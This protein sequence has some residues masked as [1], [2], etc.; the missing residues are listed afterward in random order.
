M[1]ITYRKTYCRMIWIFL[2][3]Y[4]GWF[5]SYA[6]AS[7]SKNILSGKKV[8]VTVFAEDSRVKPLL[9]SAQIRLEEILA[10]NNAYVL[11]EDKTRELTD[12]FKTLEDPSAFVTAETFVENAKKFNIDQLLAM[13]ITADV[14]PGL[15]NYY[16]ATASADIRYIENES[17]H[18]NALTTPIMGTDYRCPASDGLT[19]NSAMGNAVQRAVE[20][21]CEIFGLDMMDRIRAKSVKL[22]LTPCS[23]L[24]K[25]HIEPRTPENDRS[26]WSLPDLENAGWRQ[27]KATCTARSH[28]GKLV[29]VCGY[30]I[31]TDWHRRPQRLYGS[32]VHVLDMSTGDTL[33]K[34]ECS[35]VEKNTREE[36]RTKQILDCTFISNWR[37][38]AAATG[39]HILLWDTQTGELLS[40]LQE[41]TQSGDTLVF[42]R[43]TDGN[44]YLVLANGKQQKN[45]Y[46][47][48]VGK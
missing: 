19:R 16:T 2:C 41:Q 24:P 45:I 12:V 8:A 25:L 18:V 34:F 38:L 1:D 10:D 7:A 17:A 15:A 6:L 29:A 26:L 37:Y 28:N 39:N 11:D 43:D 21:A 9:K 48:L 5:E 23:E 47:I 40:K 27:E 3:V 44:G 20:S 14:E 13:Y 33:Y 31:D 36:R 46:R 4:L 35:P 22:K 32:R 42:A 30:I